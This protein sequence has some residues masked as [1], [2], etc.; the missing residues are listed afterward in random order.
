MFENEHETNIIGR[1][2]LGNDGQILKIS[3]LKI[4]YHILGF[5]CGSMV[6]IPSTNAGDARDVGSIHGLG[7]YPGEGDDNPF[8]YSCLENPM[9]RGAWWA[10]VHGVAKSWTHFS[11]YHFHSCVCVCVCVCVCRTTVCP[12]LKVSI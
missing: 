1:K 2:I 12:L 6:K 11:D 7:R 5:P 3:V 9:D 4:H 8:Q 10:M